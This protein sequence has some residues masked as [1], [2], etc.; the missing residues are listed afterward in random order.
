MEATVP[1]DG[2]TTG[3][4]HFRCQMLRDGSFL[5]V[6][7]DGPL[8]ATNANRPSA[9][10]W[11]GRWF[12]N[13]GAAVSGGDRVQFCGQLADNSWDFIRIIDFP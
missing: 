7:L 10:N 8:R 13:D 12:I 1:G 11:R 5:W 3:D 4:Q 6:P 9:D 2:S